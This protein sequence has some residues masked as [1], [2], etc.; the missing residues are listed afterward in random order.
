[1]GAAWGER[2]AEVLHVGWGDVLFGA[3]AAATGWGGVGAW[4]TL[5]PWVCSGGK[6]TLS[7]VCEVRMC[8]EEGGRYVC[9]VFRI[10]TPP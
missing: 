7:G 1:M 4:V 10:R 3:G 8:E 5:R 2:A 9:H 6:G